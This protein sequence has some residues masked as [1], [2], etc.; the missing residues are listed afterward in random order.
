VVVENGADSDASCTWPEFAGE[1]LQLHDFVV[2]GQLQVCPE[3]QI[4]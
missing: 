1:S 3:R 2:L 4:F